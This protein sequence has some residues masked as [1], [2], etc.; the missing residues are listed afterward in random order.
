[1]RDVI[2]SRQMTFVL[3]SSV[4]GASI[5]RPP[6]RVG[7][8]HPT[9]F[10]SNKKFCCNSIEAI[11]AT[12]DN[13]TT[14]KMGKKSK[15]GRTKQPEEE[16]VAPALREPQEETLDNLQFQDPYPE[17]YIL[18]DE[19]EGSEEEGADME[20]IQSWNPLSGQPLE[21][22]QTL[23]MDPTA[24]KM[25]HA[26]TPDWPALSFDFIRDDLGEARTRFPHSLI[27]AIGTQADR[28]DQ[29]QLTILKMSDLARMHVETDDDILGEEYNP[30]KED[31]SDEDDD[32]DD[33]VELDPIIEHFSIPHYG[34]VNR[35]RCM[36]QQS[37][38]V[39]TWS[40]AGKVHLFNVESILQRFN[41]GEGKAVASPH[42][43]PKKPFYSYDQHGSE[44][45][46]L[47]WSPVR[48]GGLATGD[49]TGNIH[50]WDPRPEGGYAVSRFYEAIDTPRSVEDLQW[51]P[52]E[53]TVLA[54]AECGGYV[55]IF[56]SR[57]PQRAML[58]H[59]IH[60]ESADVNVLSW[61]R[62]VTNLIATGG[63]DGALSVWDLRH[64]SGEAVK[65]LARFTPHKTPITSVT[66]HPTDESMLAAT[67]DDGAYIYDLSVEEDETSAGQLDVPPQLLFVHCGSQ[68]FKEVHWHPQITSCLMTTALTGFSAF[69]PSN[70]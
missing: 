43:I 23:E 40:D 4:A 68:Q 53:E 26:L 24:Y 55:R 32:S 17:E 13:T 38:I 45:Y 19:A 20:V 52:S 67:D 51:S 62:L 58:S 22:G 49:C 8:I 9:L 70:L 65:P 48:K 64:F 2:F 39:A 54:S 21:D 12:Q 50:L 35:V 11:E 59:K 1:V 57:A 3:P 46:A 66:W 27:A 7:S 30:D 25:Y 29:N 33:E 37:N 34:G 61:N 42:D 63:D 6:V 16:R 44:G 28:P 18:D 31:D 36:P 5:L 41:M 14:D 60:K 69:I 15:R 10:S 47:D 56:D